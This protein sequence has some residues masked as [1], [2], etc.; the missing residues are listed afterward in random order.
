MLP[1]MFSTVVRAAVSAVEIAVRIPATALLTAVRAAVILPVIAERAASNAELATLE[2]AP[3]AVAAAECIAER[4]PSAVSLAAVS[5]WEM[6]SLTA[7]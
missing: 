5:F 3:H 1:K 7:S 6:Y 2:I 4:I